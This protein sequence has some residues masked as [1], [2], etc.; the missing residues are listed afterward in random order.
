M[1]LLTANCSV[2]KQSNIQQ[3]LWNVRSA[4]ARRANTR[5]TNQKVARTTLMKL[6]P[7]LRVRTELL[8]V[9]FSSRSNTARVRLASV[10]HSAIILVL[11]L[12][13]RLSGHSLNIR[14]VLSC[15]HCGLKSRRRTRRRRKRTRTRTRTRRKRCQTLAA[16]R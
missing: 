6:H 2:L 15:K 16:L 11:H 5:L 10:S 3:H 8:L 12:S 9:Y 1:V 7:R 13:R 14:C 4:T